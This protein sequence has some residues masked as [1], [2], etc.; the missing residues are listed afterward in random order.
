MGKPYDDIVL[1]ISDLSQRTTINN[2]DIFLIS[3]IGASQ[4]YTIDFE[5]LR[6]RLLESTKYEVEFLNAVSEEGLGAFTGNIISNN[7]SIR[8]ALQSLATSSRSTVDEVDLLKSRV[9]TDEA[10]MSSVSNDVT[11]LT[12]NLDL[13]IGDLNTLASEVVNHVD[14]IDSRLDSLQTGLTGLTLAG[15]AGI[16]GTPGVGQII[17]WDGG[18]WIFAPDVDTDTDTNVD[19]TGYATE[20][21]VQSQGYS[22][23]GGGGGITL[24]DVA[25]DGFIKL[26]DI[27]GD[28]DVDKIYFKNVFSNLADLP[29]ATT[30][31]GMFA[32]VHATGKAYYAHGGNWIELANDADIPD[33][34]G[35]ATEAWVNAQGFSTGGGGGGGITLT[36]VANAGYVTGTDAVLK[37]DTEFQL[38]DNQ[39]ASFDF[40]EGTN[41]YLRFNTFNTG[42]KIQIMKDLWVAEGIHTAEYIRLDG[43]NKELKF[44]NTGGTGKYLGLKAPTGLASDIVFTLPGTDGTNGQ[45]LTTDGTGNFGWSTPAGGGGGA[46]TLDGLSDVSTSG[47]LN[48]QVLKYNGAS[49]APALDTEYDD[50]T[51]QALVSQL[52]TTL[53]KLVPPAPTTIDGLSVSLTGTSGTYRFCDNHTP[54]DNS[55]GNLPVAGDSVLTGRSRSVGTSNISDVGPGDSG[56]VTLRLNGNPDSQ[57]TMTTGDDDGTYGNLVISDNKDASQSTRDSGI[58][59]DFYQVYDLKAQTVTVGEGMN[60]IYFEQGTAQTQSVFWYEDATTSLS[61]NIVYGTP[62]VVGGYSTNYSSSVPHFAT[63]S[64]LKYS[65]TLHD[66]T[67]DFYNNNNN[68]LTS[69]GNNTGFTNGGNYQYDDITGGSLPPPR[70]FGQSQGEQVINGVT[71]RTRDAHVTVRWQ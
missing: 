69:S 63:N 17:K 21:W 71:V 38:T 45:V 68:V 28:L 44:Y 30:Y 19:L 56:T 36:D 51:I 23:G 5:A 8:D 52:Q 39:N 47:V 14:S 48:G 24:T 58:V 25:N 46:T 33:I 62:A 70:N 32:H 35:Y 11:D 49:W 53:N 50:S 65:C 26:T 34:T 18:S 3:D 41:V 20:A 54:V 43:D 55:T 13:T 27:S 6:T 64:E 66:I 57:H 12:T 4:S 61:P 29:S 10:N 1:K 7:S 40:K 9:A 2:G 16:N 67:G 59:A 42:E 15:I 60:G 22:T 37:T 31:H